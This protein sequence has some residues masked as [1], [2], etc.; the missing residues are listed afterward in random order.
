AITTPTATN[1]KLATATL[2]ATITPADAPVL[3]RGICWSTTSG[4]QITDNKTSEGGLTGGTFTVDIS[5][6]DK[7]STIYYKGY[8]TTPT[9]ATL[10][11]EESSFSNV[12]V[13]TGPGNWEDATRWNVQEVPGSEGDSPVINGNCTIAERKN[14]GIFCNDLTINGICTI[15]ESGKDGIQ[16]FNLTINS[17]ARLTLNAAQFFVVYGTITNTCGAEGFVIKA[18]PALPNATFAYL[19]KN[20]NPPKVKASVG[21]S[22]Q[23]N[24]DPL[25]TVEMYSKASWNLNNPAGSLYNWQ[26]FGI[27]VKTLPYSS[28]FDNCIVRRYNETSKENANLWSLQSPDS[29][30]TSGTGYELTQAVP[31]T[32]VFKGELTNADFS[33]T[34]TYSMDAKY[35]GQHIFGNPYTAAMGITMID[36]GDKTEQSVYQYNT[37]TFNDWFA[38]SGVTPYNGASGSPGQYTV[39]TVNTAGDAGIPDQIPSMQGFL[40]KTLTDEAGSIKFSY[41]DGEN[42]RINTEM[43]RAPKK[44]ATQ[45]KVITRIDVT[46]AHAADRMWIFTDPTCTRHFDNGWDGYKMMGSVLNPQLFALEADGDYQIDAVNDLNETYLGFQAGQDTEYTLKFMQQNIASTYGKAYLVDLVAGTTTDITDDGSEYTFSAVSTPTPAKRFKIVTAAT[47]DIA[48]TNTALLKVF[49]SPGVIYV[50]NRS[51]Q[52]GQL[53]LY[54]LKGVAVKTVTFSANNLTY[55][56][57]QG[58]IPGAYVGKA[59]TCNQVTNEKLIIR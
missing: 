25:A 51:D 39:S 27:P 28:A 7:S 4:V 6:L 10:L 40:V 20:S 18:D 54:D 1:I 47:G 52:K 46:S 16:C 56:S 26:F 41:G 55:I 58:L 32:Y 31:T 30:L 2:G 21:N 23:I 12:P 53:T 17:G 42:I 11:S 5:G 22:T 9:G 19:N 49:N 13:F 14:G 3:D 34:L 33:K 48:T 50:E 45:E 38:T 35:P 43:Q 57:T 37:G 15:A 8:V 44:I 36:F 29:I 59:E 24:N